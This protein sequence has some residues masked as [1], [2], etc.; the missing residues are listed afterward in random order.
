MAL[1]AL[2]LKIYNLIN[3]YIHWP[4][5]QTIPNLVYLGFSINI[6][7]GTILTIQTCTKLF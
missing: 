2:K 4:K 7:R 1:M 3:T 5:I 6:Q